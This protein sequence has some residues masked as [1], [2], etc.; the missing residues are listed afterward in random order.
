MIALSAITARSALGDRVL[1]AQFPGYVAYAR[2]ARYPSGQ[3]RSWTQPRRLRAR[4]A[5][6]S[7]TEGVVTMMVCAVLVR[8]DRVNCCRKAHPG[9][10]LPRPVCHLARALQSRVH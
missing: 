2:E 8:F 5:I 4:G 9:I 3:K 7:G 10:G 6:S 1:Q